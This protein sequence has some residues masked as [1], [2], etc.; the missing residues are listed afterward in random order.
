[1]GDVTVL[2]VG[3]DANDKQSMVSTAEEF[4]I[5]PPVNEISSPNR[6]P[7][8]KLRWA[9]DGRYMNVHGCIACLSDS[10]RAASLLAKYD[11]VWV[12]N[13]RT[14]NILR[15]WCWPHSHLD[16]D[17]V[18]STY[19]R[20]V[21]QN[22]AGGIRRLKAGV[23]QLLFRRRELL[24]RERFTTLSVCSEDDRE[25]LGGDDRIH[26]IPNGFE[27]P[28]AEP[29]RNPEVSSPRIGFIGLYTH[30][31]NFEGV[32]WFLQECWPSIRRQVPGIRFRLAG[33]GTDGPNRPLEPDVD[34]LGWIEDLT[35]EISTWSAMVVPIRIGA[36]TRVKIVDAFSRKCPVVSTS[37]GAYGY[38]VENGL[39][40][41]LA[42]SP[43][44]FALACAQVVR[45]P[46]DASEMA[47]RAWKDFLERW[48][49]DVVAPRV[50]DAAEDCLRRSRAG[51]YAQAAHAEKAIA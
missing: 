7:I 45:N 10:G 15:Q 27:R 33:K 41:C 43:Q 40:L 18:P 31:P 48:T 36:G 26:V 21:A 47:E 11:L 34:A 51:A 20:T 16:L 6:T 9:F 46:A 17:D 14:P 19:L 30:V 1:V 29:V 38:D 50:W 44:E 39:Q 24:F 49:W 12:L 25:Y 23:Q 42:D 2:M 5:E 3:S 35:A 4:E 37:F 8:Q 13:S 28:S 22:N 32:R